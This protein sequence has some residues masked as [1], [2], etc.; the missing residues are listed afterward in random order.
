MDSAFATLHIGII[1]FDLDLYKAELCM[2]GH[3]DYG[4][5]IL[6]VSFIFTYLFLSNVLF[7]YVCILIFFI[8]V[9]WHIGIQ[10]SLFMMP[11]SISVNRIIREACIPISVTRGHYNTDIQGHAAPSQRTPSVIDQHSICWPRSLNAII[12]IIHQHKHVLF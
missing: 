6:K 12:K 4:L 2:K 5:N 7:Q 11:G 3:I 1:G 9:F 8:C 10:S